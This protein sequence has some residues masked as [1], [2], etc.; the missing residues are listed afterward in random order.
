MCT[1]LIAGVSLLAVAAS[2]ATAAAAPITL[3]YTGG[4]VNYT[5]P[6]TGLYLISQLGSV[7]YSRIS[8]NQ[9]FATGRTWGI[10][11]P[12]ATVTPR[13]MRSCLFS[14][15]ALHVPR[16]VGWRRCLSAPGCRYGCRRRRAD[17]DLPAGI[18]HRDAGAHLT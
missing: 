8:F 14:R 5:A 6:V 18:A 2:L 7:L 15:P 17:N 4:I 3:G 11:C 16:A 10:S 12:W 13:N 9:V 1:L